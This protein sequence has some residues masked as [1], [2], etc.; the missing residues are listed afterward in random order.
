MV[1]FPLW[2][3]TKLTLCEQDTQLNSLWSG[4]NVGNFTNSMLFAFCRWG[5]LTIHLNFFKT[6][7]RGSNWRLII[8][9]SGNGLVP[10]DSKPLPEPMMTKFYDTMLSSEINI[11]QAWL[12]LKYPVIF[13]M[14]EQYFPEQYLII[15]I[16]KPSL[17]TYA[18]WGTINYI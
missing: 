5:L 2:P 9:G 10:S 17:S 7:S 1:L 11:F 8:I 12:V 14:A 3:F 16:I 15:N 18:K 13:R 6:C 4:Q